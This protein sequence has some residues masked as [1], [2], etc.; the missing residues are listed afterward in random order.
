MSIKFLYFGYIKDLFKK[1]FDIINLK[2]CNFN[3]KLEVSSTQ[4]IDCVLNLNK[5]ENVDQMKIQNNKIDF[6]T[7]V[8]DICLLALNDEFIDKKEAIKL[9]DN[10]VISIIPPVSGG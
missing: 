6:K 4:L 10:D 9:S 2:E 5:I 1:E 8:Y 3:E 7:Y